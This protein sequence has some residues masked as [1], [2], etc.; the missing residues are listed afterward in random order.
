MNWVSKIIEGKPDEF[1]HAK[2]VKYGM[3]SY[4]GPRIN[5]T[6]SKSKIGFKADLDLEKIFLKGYL[7]TAPKGSHKVSGLIESYTDRQDEF[8]TLRMPLSWKTAKK[9]GATTYKAKL[10]EVAPIEDISE[11]VEKDGPTIFF[12][13]S[14]SPRDGSKPWKIKTKTSYPKAPKGGEDSGKEKA[15]TFVVGA[16]ANTPE[17]LE[18]IM[19]ETLSDFRDST[20]DKTKK[21]N[22]RHE[23]IIEDIEIPENPS[24]S[25]SEK[26][27]L[28]KKRGKLIRKATIDGQ[29]YQKEYT[30]FA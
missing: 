10:K 3:G 9:K 18:Y 15:P 29:E 20:N 30:F 27:K 8:A 24:L 1:V 14:M 21:V 7:S 17:S 26:R 19:N 6:I 4:P 13:L 25:F 28:A 2:L 22:I 23:I 16:Y 12:L 5:L 11:I